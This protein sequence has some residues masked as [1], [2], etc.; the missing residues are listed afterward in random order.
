MEINYLSDRRH[1]KNSKYINLGKRF[2]LFNHWRNTIEVLCT[3]HSIR[4]EWRFGFRNIYAWHFNRNKYQMSHIVITLW[5]ISFTSRFST[6]TRQVNCIIILFRYS[7]AFIVIFIIVFVLV[8]IIVLVAKSPWSVDIVIR[9]AGRACFTFG[10]A[11][12][13]DI[14]WD[15][16]I[17]LEQLLGEGNICGNKFRINFGNVRAVCSTS[18]VNY[19][20]T[21]PYLRTK[22][23]IKELLGLRKFT[24]LPKI[25]A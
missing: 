5:F 16:L 22:L 8:I 10:P 11:S 19:I 2:Q 4:N 25:R 12:F 17:P 20:D 14:R 7:N 1:R 24:L 15:S 13:T 9:F 21:V 18:R 23:T 6:H 3:A